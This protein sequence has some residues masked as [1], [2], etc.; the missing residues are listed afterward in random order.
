M[1]AEPES[2]PGGGQTPPPAP[3]FGAETTEDQVPLAVRSLGA[4]FTTA[5]GWLS[6][7]TWAT[8]AFSSGATATTAAEI[9]PNA[10]Y[11]NL[12][13]YGFPLGLVLTGLVGWLLLRPVRSI[14][15]RFALSVVGVLGGITLAMLI[16]FLADGIGGPIALLGAGI[17]SLVAAAALGLSA[18]RAAARL[19]VS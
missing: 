5:I 10:F 15:R 17:L 18:R 1:T 8:R 11:V 4:Q 14:W 19:S 9:D 3:L 13:L 2:P 12:L 7:L 6:L 16:T